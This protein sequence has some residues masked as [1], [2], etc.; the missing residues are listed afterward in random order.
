MLIAHLVPGY[1]AA[2][3][4]AGRQV[5]GWSHR[6]RL[7]AWSVALGSTVAPDTDVLYNAIFR[8]FFNHSWLWTHSLFPYLG[9]GLLWIGLRAYARWPF[10]QTLVGLAVVGGLSHLLLDV[11]AHSTPL[12]YPLWSAMI[13]FSSARVQSGGVVGY[14]TDPIFLCEPLLLSLAAA[15]WV[16]NHRLSRRTTQ[17]AL[18]G[19]SGA[20]LAFVFLFLLLLPILQEI[21]VF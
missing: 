6:Q 19:V 15:H 11:I 2:E 21:V 16:C 1:F 17:L 4:S 14:L 18:V 7:V 13:G 10:G 20:T 12:F 5:A 9:V 3:W 8:G